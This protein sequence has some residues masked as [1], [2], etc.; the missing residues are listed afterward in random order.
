MKN[1][2]FVDFNNGDIYGRVR[3]TTVGTVNDLNRLGLKLENGM[4]LLLDDNDGVSAIGIVQFSELENIW[5][6]IIDREK[7]GQ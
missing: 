2:I 7:L 4:E 1:S 5:V 6:A 3:L